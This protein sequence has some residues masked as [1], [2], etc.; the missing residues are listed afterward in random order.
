MTMRPTRPA[1]QSP[2]LSARRWPVRAAAV[3]A[4]S[5]A[6]AV[7]LGGCSSSTVEADATPASPTAASPTPE[8]SSSS[9]APTSSAP[10]GDSDCTRVVTADSSN[11]EL[12]EA[13]TAVLDALDCASPTDL[14]DQ[15]TALYEDPEFQSQATAAGWQLGINTVDV[16]G[17]TTAISMVD[18]STS[19]SCQVQVIT[20]PRTIGL[21]CG[22]A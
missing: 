5:L 6:V 13:A 8:A 1:R 11:T 3:A 21:I 18:L 19:S 4:L 2:S 16:G 15:L 17:K 7:S 20:S 14:H 10:A 12:Q 9:A 22:D